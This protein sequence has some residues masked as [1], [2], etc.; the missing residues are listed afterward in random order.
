MKVIAMVSLVWAVVYLPGLGSLEIKGEEG[1]RI[2]PAIAMIESGDA[3]RD[4]RETIRSYIVPR[5]GSEAYLRKPPLINWLVAASFK[6]FGQ[7]TEWTAR[8]PSALSVLIVAIVFVIVARPSLGARGSTI[9]ALVWLTNVGIIEKGRL[10]EIEALYASLFALAIICWLAFWEQKRSAWLTW[11]VPWIFLGLGWLAKGPLHLFF[12]YAIVLAVLWRAGEVRALWNLPH[13]IGIIVMLCI[14]AAWAIPFAQMTGQEHTAHVWAKQF[15]GRLTESIHWKSWALNTPKSLV[16]FL[17]WLGL[18][19]FIASR[20]H[21]LSPRLRRTGRLRPQSALIWGIVVPLVIVD[22]IPGALPRYTL[23]LAAPF[24]WLLGSMMTEETG[25]WQRL[26]IG[27][28]VTATCIAIWIYAFA[29]IP[30][31]RPRLRPIAAKIDKIV[32]ESERLYAIDPD[33]QPFLFY[34]HRPIFYV[35]SA[36]DLPDDTKFFLVQSDEEDAVLSARKW[37]RTPS[38]VLSIQDY[39]DWRVSLFAVP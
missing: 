6:I 22:L 14:F 32:P 9:A 21:P 8:L 7:R 30:R 26:V 38:R 20:D 13:L 16:Y 10:I 29:V 35:G 2:L 28:I 23:P 34:V 18:L 11:F 25:K 19:P 3:A 36:T 31:L 4:A 24:A 5:I 1:R 12:F 37:P 17:P 39:R 15:S 33:Y 27:G